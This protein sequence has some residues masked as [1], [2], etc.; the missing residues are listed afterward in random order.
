MKTGRNLFSGHILEFL[1]QLK[2]DYTSG[3]VCSGIPGSVCSI[4]GGS[5]WAGKGGLI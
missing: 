4:F 2:G 1:N 3:S 5:V